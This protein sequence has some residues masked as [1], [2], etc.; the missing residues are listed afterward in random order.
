M[1][2]P[3]ADSLDVQPSAAAPVAAGAESTEADAAQMLRNRRI[4]DADTDGPYSHG[5]QH[6]CHHASGAASDG[7]VEPGSPAGS[8][9]PRGEAST[10]RYPEAESPEEREA[11][12][13]A[14][15]RLWQA[16]R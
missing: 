5:V 8:T 9:A 11:K 7:R 6:G 2:A 4:V 13:Q 14:R 15:L 1:S 16:I 12:R 10:H 3:V